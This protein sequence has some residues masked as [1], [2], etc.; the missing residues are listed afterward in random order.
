MSGGAFNT[1]AFYGA[2]EPQYSKNNF[3]GDLLKIDFASGIARNALPM[4]GGGGANTPN[5]NKLDR[6]ILKKIRNI[7]KQV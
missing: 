6:I 4:I 2:V 7:L 1:A 3:T 5:C